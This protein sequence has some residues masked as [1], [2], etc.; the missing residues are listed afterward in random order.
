MPKDTYFSVT[1]AVLSTCGLSVG[2]YIIAA[3]ISLPK[4]FATVYMGYALTQS[5]GTSAYLLR[6]REYSVLIAK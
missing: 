5:K 2:T 6:S 3:I 4:Q 1:T